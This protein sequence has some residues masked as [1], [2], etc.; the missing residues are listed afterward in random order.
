MVEI[1]DA[2][3]RNM[4][5]TIA[6]V[7]GDF[8]KAL[9]GSVLAHFQMRVLRKCLS[10][11]TCSEMQE[12]LSFRGLHFSRGV[13]REKLTEKKIINNEEVF[14]SPF[15]MSLINREKLCVNRAKIGVS[16]KGSPE[17]C[18]FRFFPFFS[19][20]FRFF[21]F[22][23]V[24]S[25]FSFRFLPFF[26]FSSVCSVFFPFFSFFFRFF[27]FFSV[28]FRFFPFLLFFRVP[29]FSVFSVFFPFSSVFFPFL[30][31]FFRFL[32][33]FSVFFRFFSVSF[34]EKNGETPFAR[35]LLRNPEKIGTKNPP[36]FHR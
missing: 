34:S 10:A 19:V 35:P 23:S 33:F 5:L 29:I 11:V 17:R 31:V 7:F 6:S 22:F 32:P 8:V 9:V 36:F 24:F 18:R 16:Q 20:F 28:S 14:F 15:N 1:R 3:C 2:L 30:S 27:P 26:P 21:P 12:L 13:N 25:L 4:W